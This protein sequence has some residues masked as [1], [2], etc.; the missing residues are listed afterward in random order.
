MEIGICDST[1]DL[2]LEE[3]KE[4]PLAEPGPTNGL[5]QAE[6][7]EVSG[8]AEE[9]DWRPYDPTWLVELAREQ[10]ADRPWLAEALS[11]CTRAW[12]SHEGYIHF[13]DT[14]ERRSVSSDQLN[15]PTEGW[16][17]L[18]IRKDQI[19]VGVE[20]YN[21]LNKGPGVTCP[22][23]FIHNYKTILGHSW[24]TVHDTEYKQLLALEGT[25]NKADGT[26]AQRLRGALYECPECGRLMWRRPG[27][28]TYQFFLPEK[29]D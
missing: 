6:K 15:S 18:D 13:V 25:G 10:R 22:C 26:A 19:V 11:R 7:Q 27:E 28:R 23:G 1:M 2:C 5:Y 12:Q 24:L 14:A 29:A 4:V 8:M 17:L 21:K 9:P 20:I 16:L 3:V